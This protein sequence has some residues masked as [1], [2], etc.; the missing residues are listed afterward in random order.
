MVNN[1]NYAYMMKKILSFNI[2]RTKQLRTNQVEY[3]CDNGEYIK[4]FEEI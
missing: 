1:I 2:N 3:M 4:I